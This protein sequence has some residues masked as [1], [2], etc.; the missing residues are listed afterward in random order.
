MT[1]VASIEPLTTS[2]FRDFGTVMALPDAGGRRGYDDALQNLR[3]DAAASLALV[4]AE[5]V[6]RLPVTARRMERHAR[7]SQT[8]LPLNAARMLILVAPAGASGGP[9][10]RRARA[11]VAANGV[12]ITYAANVW[13]HPLTIL[14]PDAAFAVL[15]WRDGGPLDEEFVDIA[16]L[17]VM[18]GR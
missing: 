15:M 1:F 11:F 18:E 5:D 14:T 12:G 17:T 13:H 4:R 7:S 10:M 6:A 2:A 16:P 8:I 3:A 9:D